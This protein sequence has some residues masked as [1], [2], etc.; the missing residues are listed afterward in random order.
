MQTKASA[1]RSGVKII[2]VPTTPI[3]GVAATLNVH[4]ISTLVR[5]VTEAG[6][7]GVNLWAEHD[8]E[9]EQTTYHCDVGQSHHQSSDLSCCILR[10]GGELPVRE[11]SCC[12]KKKPIDFFPHTLGSKYNRGYYCNSCNNRSSRKVLT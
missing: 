8:E 4:T 5:L 1:S 12:H 6:P 7:A 10:A 11:C 2:H 3:T 9:V